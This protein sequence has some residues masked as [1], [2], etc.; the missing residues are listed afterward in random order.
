MTFAKEVADRVLFMDG[1]FFI[2]EGSALQVI[3]HPQQ[4]RTK[5]FLKRL[6]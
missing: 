6:L 5:A 3:D 2:E 1:G 4:E